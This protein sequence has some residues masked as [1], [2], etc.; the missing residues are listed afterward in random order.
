MLFMLFII[1]GGFGFFVVKTYNHLQGRSHEVREAHSNIVVSMKKRID[2]ANKLIDIASSYGDHEKLTHISIAKA[3]SDTAVIAASAEV[4]GALNHV[5]KLATVYPELKASETYGMLMRQLEDVESNLQ[6]R[7]ER[8]NAFVRGYNTKLSQLPTNLF[9]PALGFRSAPYFNVDDADSL[10]ALKDFSSADGEILRGMLADAGR[11][12][13]GSTKDAGRKMVGMGKDAIE[14]GRDV[15]DRY[16]ASRR[17]EA[18]DQAG[19][20]EQLP[21]GPHSQGT[22]DALG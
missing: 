5:V 18:G 11:K 19:N 1:V 17:L 7:R 13:I 16:Q 21:V 8:Y 6:D 12:A 4:A 15:A 2:L 9:A 14:I 10:D 3:D 20:G 22:P